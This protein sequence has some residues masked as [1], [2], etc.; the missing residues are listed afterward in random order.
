MLSLNYKQNTQHNHVFPRS[1][2]KELLNVNY[3][4]DLPPL[5]KM[6]IPCIP[7]SS[8]N[9]TFCLVALMFGLEGFYC[10]TYT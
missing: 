2:W 9:R 8:L 4:V 6:K 1:E 10:N 5:E 7:E 3:G